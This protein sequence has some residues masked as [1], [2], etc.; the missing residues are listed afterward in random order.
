M[1][2]IKNRLNTKT[3]KESDIKSV[4]KGEFMHKSIHRTQKTSLCVK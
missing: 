3:S 2:Q 4:D 1:T